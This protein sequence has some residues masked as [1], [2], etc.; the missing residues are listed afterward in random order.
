MANQTVLDKTAEKQD[1]LNNLLKIG[2][3]FK[4]LNNR[5]QFY[6]DYW[7]FEKIDAALRL[8]II[9]FKPELQNASFEEILEALKQ[10]TPEEQTQ[11]TVP[12]SLLEQLEKDLDQTTKI[13]EEA[14]Q[15]AAALKNE[16]LDKLT[17]SPIPSEKKTAIAGS[18]SK[19][20]SESLEK[21]DLPV[22]SYKLEQTPSGAE[23]N[24][25]LKEQVQ[26][27]FSEIWEEAVAKTAEENNLSAKEAAFLGSL[28]A[29][30]LQIVKP[31]ENRTQIS[32]YQKQIDDRFKQTPDQQ[33]TDRYKDEITFYQEKI[34]NIKGQQVDNIVRVL[35]PFFEAE[36]A[37]FFSDEFFKLFPD[38]LARYSSAVPSSLEIEEAAL[39]TLWQMVG[40]QILLKPEEIAA[41]SNSLTS[42]DLSE[43][44]AYKKLSLLPIFISLI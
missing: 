2:S 43:I 17:Q 10:L 33:I 44:I 31:I 27:R 13:T 42:A 5:E 4:D 21:S 8:W 23:E 40:S 32:Q 38:N 34:E 3:F 1:S 20:L 25:Q 24:L 6:D 26:Q 41:V 7:T 15:K 11:T 22:L 19:N 16:F 12:T 36:K 37:K 35:S 9:T 39:A 30:V 28:S 29:P 14:R 18:L